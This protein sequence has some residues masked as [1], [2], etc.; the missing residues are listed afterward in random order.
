M[1]RSHPAVEEPAKMMTFSSLSGQQVEK[2]YPGPLV[3]KTTRLPARHHCCFIRMKMDVPQTP[4]VF[5]LSEGNVRLVT[6]QMMLHIS[7]SSAGE[8]TVTLLRT[9]VYWDF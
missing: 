6:V 1:D 7:L 4:V 9:S 3:V 8:N 2:T 5:M